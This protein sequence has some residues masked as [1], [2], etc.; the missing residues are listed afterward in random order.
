SRGSVGHWYENAMAESFFATL[1]CA[2]LAR[3]TLRTHLEART[4]LFEYLE[5]FSTRQRRHSALAYQPPDAYERVH[6]PLS[7][8]PPRWGRVFSLCWGS[9]R[10]AA[11]K[12]K[13]GARVYCR[14]WRRCP[15]HDHR[16]VGAIPCRP[17][18]PWRRWRCCVG[19]AAC[20]PSPS[21]AANNPKR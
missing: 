15:T 10:L 14:H 9:G 19:P 1:E 16:T 13:N 21:G 4:A 6:I 5:V 18:S 17:F 2:L 7:S 20:T 11:C 12:P 3:Q 8:L